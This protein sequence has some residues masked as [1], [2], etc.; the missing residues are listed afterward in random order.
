[1]CMG[2]VTRAGCGAI[3]PGRGDTCEG[4]RGLLPD[5]N[6]ASHQQMLAEHGNPPEEIRLRYLM[7][8]AYRCEELGVPLP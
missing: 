2:P 4:C 3:C 7:F 8:N 5:G 1:M 6:F